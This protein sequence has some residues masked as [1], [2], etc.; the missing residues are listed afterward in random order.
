MIH[1]LF[2]HTQ[3]YVI[4][5]IGIFMFKLHNLTLTDIKFNKLIIENMNI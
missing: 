5:L 3:K 2:F 1:K 4:N